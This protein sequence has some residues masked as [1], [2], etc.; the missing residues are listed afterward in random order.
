PFIWLH[1]DFL[2]DTSLIEP[3]VPCSEPVT[4][5]QV[6]AHDTARNHRSSSFVSLDTA[7]RSNTLIKDFFQGQIRGCLRGGGKKSSRY[8]DS[9]NKSLAGKT[10]QCCD[11]AV[12]GTVTCDRIIAQYTPNATAKPTNHE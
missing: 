11:T 2:E 7:G 12:F 4:S 3:V 10:H 8:K 5:D 6:T 9:D 1:N